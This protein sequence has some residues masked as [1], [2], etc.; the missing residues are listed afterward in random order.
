LDYVGD[1][2]TYG[3]NMGFPAAPVRQK[4]GGK[5]EKTENYLNSES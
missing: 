1:H 2:M 4:H 5:Y 3:Q